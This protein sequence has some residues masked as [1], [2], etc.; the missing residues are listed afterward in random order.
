MASRRFDI[1]HH[2]RWLIV[3]KTMLRAMA[4]STGIV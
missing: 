2:G 3:S 4:V 1:R